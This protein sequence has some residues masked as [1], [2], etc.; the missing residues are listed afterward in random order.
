MF[1]LPYAGWALTKKQS[2]GSNHQINLKKR[3]ANDLLIIVNLGEGYN[4]NQFVPLKDNNS[5]YYTISTE[6][7]NVHL[8]CNGPLQF[9]FE[10]WNEVHDMINRSKKY[11]QDCI[12]R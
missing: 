6:C 11:L 3:F 10:Q 5:L 9:T 2:S 7:I 1:D 4:H 12:I 8:S